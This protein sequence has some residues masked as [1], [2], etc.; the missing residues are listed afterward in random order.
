[1]RVFAERLN[2]VSSSKVMPSVEFD[3]GMQRIVLEDRIGDFQ[4]R[5]R[6][7]AARHGGDAGQ[8]RDLANRIIRRGG[9]GRRLHRRRLERVCGAL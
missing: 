1:M 9:R 6:G 5:W 2:V 4:R 8:R 7:I 3:A